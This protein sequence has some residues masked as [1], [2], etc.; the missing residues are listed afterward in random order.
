MYCE[1]SISSHDHFLF[2]SV[3]TSSIRISLLRMINL[4][5]PSTSFCSTVSPSST[6]SSYHRSNLSPHPHSNPP[7]RIAVVGG[8]IT[9]LVTTYYA[10]KRYPNAS[11]TL[12]ESSDR[13][14]GVIRSKVVTFPNGE[15]AVCE[16][17]ART[18][19]ANA[20]RAIVM[21]DLVCVLS[22]PIDSLRSGH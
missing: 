9:G 19:R 17:G 22:S 11:I 13:L 1:T 14:G 16:M 10:A 18:L 5:R 15:S 20:P 8:G 12:F 21:I 7:Q 2:F 6:V 4:C 3:M